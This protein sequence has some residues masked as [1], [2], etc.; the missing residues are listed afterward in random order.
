MKKHT[1]LIREVISVTAMP[2]YGDR[3]RDGKLIVFA[4]KFMVGDGEA[5]HIAGDRAVVYI[6]SINVEHRAEMWLKY[7][8]K[9]KIISHIQ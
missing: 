8:Y 3:Y 9:S 4:K 5:P 1:Q 6:A 2:Y 7:E